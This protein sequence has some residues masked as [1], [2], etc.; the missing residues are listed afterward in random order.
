MVASRKMWHHEQESQTAMRKLSWTLLL[1]FLLLF[2]QQGAMRHEYSHYLKQASSSEKA[3]VD[4]DHCLQCLAF[5]QIGS[6]A[7]ADAPTPALLS[8]LSFELEGHAPVSSAESLLTT[9]RSRG[10]PV[11]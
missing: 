2:V 4:A 6:I 5:A 3:P 11:L 7:Q 8:G 1:P 10:P 9:P